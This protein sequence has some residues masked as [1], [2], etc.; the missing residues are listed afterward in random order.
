MM[1]PSRH[2]DAVRCLPG[3]IGGGLVATA[4]LA[5]ITISAISL[6][7][8][9]RRGPPMG[10]LDGTVTVDGAALDRGSVT[11]SKPGVA[12][13]GDVDKTGAFRIPPVPM[14][15][16][17]VGFDDHVPSP[18][19]MENGA[20]YQKLPVHERYRSPATSGIECEIKPGRNTAVFRLSRN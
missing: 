6:A 7:G 20:R 1:R 15:V 17:R 13:S 11:I 3:R 19:A 9:G 2:A 14:G 10:S 16:Y 8:C 18:E 12:A 5:V 4:C